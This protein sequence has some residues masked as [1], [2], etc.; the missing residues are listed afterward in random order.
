MSALRLT[1]ACAIAALGG[2]LCAHPVDLGEHAFAVLAIMLLVGMPHGALDHALA[3]RWEGGATRGEQVNFHIGYVA[4]VAMVILVWWLAPVA[5]LVAFLAASAWHFGESDLLHLPAELRSRPAILTRGL[6]L[7]AGGIAI[8]P[9]AIIGL[10]DVVTSFQRLPLPLPSSSQPAYLAFALALH[11]FT[12]WGTETTDHP[13]ARLGASLDAA[14]LALLL[15]GGGLTVGLAVYFVA[16]H[17]PDH[18][19]AVR[20]RASWRELL[21][22]AAPRTILAAAGVCALALWLPVE[23]WAA[24]V[25]VGIA[26]LTLPH[27][28]V[29]H[30]TMAPEAT[31][32]AQEA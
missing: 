13:G 21:R 3:G 32:Q 16:W 23:T 19:A 7:I 26:A 24:A 14:A 30:L 12:L 28:F 18:V 17:T 31:L 6:L 9:Q 4:T 15:L 29:V 5:G 10:L 2:L 22:A 20:G 1:R 25:V 27:A 8:E 11:L